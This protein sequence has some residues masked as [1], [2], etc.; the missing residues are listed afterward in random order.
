MTP[1]EFRS[2]RSTLGLS[3]LGLAQSLEISRASV[4][5]WESGRWPVPK[6]ITYALAYM[7][8]LLERGFE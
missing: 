7:C 2:I 6:T 4:Q 1:D 3:Q 8:V 5:R